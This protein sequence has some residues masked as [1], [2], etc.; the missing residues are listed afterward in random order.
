MKRQNIPKGHTANHTRRISKEGIRCPYCGSPAL[1][2]DAS[3]VY[4]P[5]SYGGKVYVCSHYPACDS[6]VG[7]HQGTALPKGSLAD[8]SLRKKRIL[9]HQTFD[10]IW[11]H[12]ILNRQDAYRWLA[13]KFCLEIWQAHIGNFSDYMC[14][15]LIQ[16]ASKV[17]QNNHV[18]LSMAG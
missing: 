3:Y 7:V 17:L 1:L 16:E 2:K 10:Q 11:K 14:E 9:A 8:R 6:Y 4:G 15:Q 18:P 12:G 13:D 5:D